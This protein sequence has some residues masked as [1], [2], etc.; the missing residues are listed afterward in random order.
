MNRTIK[1]LCLAAAAP[2]APGSC[3]LAGA[4]PRRSYAFA[5][6]GGGGGGAQAFQVFNRRTKWLQKERAASNVEASRQA[7]YL[8]D[9]VANR[10][11]ERLLDIKRRFPRVLDLG[12]NS[13][14][15]ARALTRENPD[16]DPAK[17]ITPALSAR[18][19]ELVA[20][21]S[22]HALLHRDADLPFNANINITRQVLVDEEH[23]PFPPETFDLVLS[24]LSLHWINDLPG[25]LTQINNVLKPD[26]PF[27]GAM[28]GGDSLFE[29]R[30]SL[31]LAEQERRGGISPHVSPLADTR[32]VGG[33][34]QRAGFKMLTVDVDDIVVD[35][36][37]TF[38]LM[39]DL[40]AMGEGNAILGREMGPIRREVLLANEGIY[41][42]LH[43]NEDG[44][45]PATF[46]IIYMI[47]WREG[48][49][50]PKPLPRG[51]GD[52]NLKDILES[53]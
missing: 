1:R 34:M 38:A 13:C 5:S 18:I 4:V 51:T 6:G 26:S 31:Q 35:Y 36:P 25:V 44:S 2:S 33:L 21:E 22:S 14:N 32:D 9:E 30:T 48:G 43:G 27:M 7:D 10:L 17:P 52:V 16:P 23:V 11:C 41:R 19:D 50:Q 8:K 42:E 24:S 28:I 15:V 3:L 39:Q 29:L 46:R 20:A 49:D 53:N 40:Q 45:I 37:D 12:A 47:G